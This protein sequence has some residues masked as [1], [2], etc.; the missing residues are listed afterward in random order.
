MSEQVNMEILG[1]TVREEN[2]QEI[3]SLSSKTIDIPWPDYEPENVTT[4]IMQRANVA[5]LLDVFSFCN[6]GVRQ[7]GFVVN[8]SMTF[9]VCT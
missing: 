5:F 2:K 1:T 9:E 3:E 8:D 4:M 7:N 6:T